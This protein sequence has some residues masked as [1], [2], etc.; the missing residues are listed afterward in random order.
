M[1]IRIKTDLEA[2]PL[3]LAVMSQFLK[4]EDN[5]T[6]E[7]TLIS[8]M[9]SSVRTILE[10]RTGLVFASKTFEV[11]FDPSDYPFVIPV[12]PIISVDSMVAID[13]QG[14]ETD[15]TLNTDYYKTGMYE[16]DLIVNSL[17]N[18]DVM[19]ESDKYKDRYKVTC[20]AGYGDDDTETLP[21]ALLNAMQSQVFQWYQNRDDFMEGNVL[22]LIDKAVMLFKREFI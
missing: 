16:I 3:T 15:L 2:E 1:N 9:I 12:Y 7:N 19:A 18:Y 17:L 5:Q 21:V 4:Y 13:Y 20:K 11:Y 6:A 14:T 8:S 22:G 10:E